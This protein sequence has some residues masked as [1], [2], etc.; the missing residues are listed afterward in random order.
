MSEI[1]IRC[2]QTGRAI[3]TGLTTDMV[4]LEALPPIAFPRQCPACGKVHITQIWIAI[5]FHRLR[6]RVSSCGR[7]L[8][9]AKAIITT[10]AAWIV[11]VNTMSD[12][13]QR[14]LRLPSISISPSSKKSGSLSADN[15]GMPALLGVER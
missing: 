12:K 11:I 5:R 2:P 8:T 1:L 10:A 7:I 14:Q 13:P 3:S 6:L 4:V 15:A 9:P